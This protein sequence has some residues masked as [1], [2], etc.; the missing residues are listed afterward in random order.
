MDPL[1]FPALT[2]A[3]SSSGP[4]SLISFPPGKRRLRFLPA[5]QP[6]TQAPP[7]CSGRIYASSVV[8]NQLH[9]LQKLHKFQLFTSLNPAPR[10]PPITAHKT[11]RD[12]QAG[13]KPPTAC[14]LAQEAMLL[15]RNVE[16]SF[17]VRQ[18]P[19]QKVR[20]RLM[21]NLAKPSY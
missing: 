15:K 3:C 2:P 9:R 6:R 12:P 14:L 20:F 4:P 21:Q 17:F 7:R 19:S 11:H 8:T 18:K 5:A 1:V 10:H 13:E 16:S